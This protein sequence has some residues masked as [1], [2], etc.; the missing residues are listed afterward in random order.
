MKNFFLVRFN[1]KNQRQRRER[2]RSTV[3]DSKMVA[4]EFKLN[5]NPVVF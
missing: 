5:I 1:K 4:N 3:T 2:R